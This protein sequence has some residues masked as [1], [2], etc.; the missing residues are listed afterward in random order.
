MTFTIR[1]PDFSINTTNALS[2]EEEKEDDRISSPITSLTSVVS[3]ATEPVFS[4]AFDC[5]PDC[6]PS[7]EK[8]YLTT[9]ERNQEKTLALAKSEPLVGNTLLAVS[10]FFG[11]N[12]ASVRADRYDGSTLDYIVMIDRSFRIQKLWKEIQEIVLQSSLNTEAL[13]RIKKVLVDKADK[14][15]PSCFCDKPGC[16]AKSKSYAIEYANS[17]IEDLEKEVLTEVSWLSSQTKF[18]KIKHIF[19]KR[20]F[21]F[22]RLDFFDKKNMQLLSKTFKHL[23]L[24]LDTS[25]LSNIREYA[26]ISHQLTNFR[27]SIAELRLSMTDKTLIIDTEPRPQELFSSSFTLNQRVFRKIVSADLTLCFP[28]SPS[29]SISFF[30]DLVPLLRKNNQKLIITICP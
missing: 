6:F 20:H 25:Y 13:S 24:T 19:D 22:K 9:N 17:Y 26:E 28:Q 16:E 12:V 11:L 1:F 4:Q 10:G 15:W 3:S 23:R 30:S 5:I 8:I 18:L 21:I 2:S 27:E 29:L 7:N 14:F